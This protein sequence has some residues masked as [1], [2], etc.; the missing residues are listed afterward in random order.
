[1]ARI[2]EGTQCAVCREVLA[3]GEVLQQMPCLHA[4]HPDCLKPWLVSD[5]LD[6]ACPPLAF[7]HAFGHSLE[8]A[9]VTGSETSCA[10]VL[11]AC[12]L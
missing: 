3:V 5:L 8:C 2:G 1:V 4:Y 7:S 12:A 6:R 9:L 11:T 10:T